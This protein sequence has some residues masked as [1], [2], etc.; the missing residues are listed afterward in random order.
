MYIAVYLKRNIFKEFQ[1]KRAFNFLG[2]NSE[3][4]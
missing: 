3:K 1:C 2:E 4:Y